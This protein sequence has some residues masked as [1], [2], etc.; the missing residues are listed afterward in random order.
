MKKTTQ[1]KLENLIRRLIKE[2]DS[3]DLFSIAKEWVRLVQ[4]PNG[5]SNEQKLNELG[6]MLF[7]AGIL[8]KNPEYTPG[9]GDT[10][11]QWMGNKRLSGINQQIAKYIASQ[12]E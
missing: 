2:E 7:N 5:K 8:D 11:Y 10:K 4:S 1:M 6:K 3:G 9:I 12:I